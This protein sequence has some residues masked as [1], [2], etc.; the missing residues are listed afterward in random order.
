ML[1]AIYLRVL[2]LEVLPEEPPLLRDAPPEYPLLL[3]A[4]E[5]E[6]LYEEELLPAELRLYV[7]AEPELYEL[8]LVP[9]LSEERTEL[10]V[11]MLLLPLL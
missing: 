2:E 4:D 9:V 11:P 10:E 7:A 1:S 5:E 6:L 3:L 8:R